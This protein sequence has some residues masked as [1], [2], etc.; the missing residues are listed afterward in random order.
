MINQIVIVDE[1][2]DGL[3]DFFGLCADHAHSLCTEHP[4]NINNQQFGSDDVSTKNISDILSNV[5]QR[6]FIFLSFVHGDNNSMFNG[7]ECFVS[8]TDNYYLFS[9]SFIYTFSCYTGNDLA[10]TLL[11][12]GVIAF[13]GYSK[14]AWV[15]PS[16][17]DEFKKAAMSGYNHF[18]N[19][20][21]AIIAYNRMIEDTNDQIN[22]MY[23]KNMIVAS[24]LMKNR[25]ALILKGN[26][27]LTIG[28]FNI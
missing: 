8:T 1:Q 23:K 12:N 11:M 9:N 17:F 15:L 3:G 28:D 22:E 2:D 13:L 6:G 16:Y 10:D 27:G 18:L 5:N 14:E 24:Y 7:S 21:S 25:D 4:C 19:G 20:D 26:K